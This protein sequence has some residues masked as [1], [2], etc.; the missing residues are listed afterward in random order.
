M[1]YAAKKM[2]KLTDCPKSLYAS[3]SSS[4]LLLARCCLPT[5]IHLSSVR[6]TSALEVSQL[7]CSIHRMSQ[8]SSSS[9]SREWVGIDDAGRMYRTGQGREGEEGEKGGEGC[10]IR[11]IILHPRPRVDL[12]LAGLHRFISNVSQIFTGANR[13]RGL[14]E[15]I[16]ID[17]HQQAPSTAYHTV[18][19]LRLLRILLGYR[20]VPSV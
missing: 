14:L 1:D 7:P 18:S 19:H 16:R 11:D 13:P 4:F 2:S 20:Y 8:R 5:W 12:Q 10:T 3:Y 9:V 17:I 15:H 6:L